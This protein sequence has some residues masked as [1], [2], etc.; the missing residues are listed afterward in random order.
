MINLRS[1]SAL[2]DAASPPRATVTAPWALRGWK[3]GVW[4]IGPQANVGA[5]IYEL[6]DLDHFPR[7]AAVPVIAISLAFRRPPRASWKRQ[8]ISRSSLTWTSPHHRKFSF[9]GISRFENAGLYSAE[10]PSI[11]I[12]QDIQIRVC[13]DYARKPDQV[14]VISMTHLPRFTPLFGAVGGGQGRVLSLRFC[15]LFLL[16]VLSPAGRATVTGPRPTRL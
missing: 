10:P 15:A 2:G 8:T 13:V 11:L 4:P 1:L 5:V 3:S 6:P 7:P 14:A 16:V 9:L 12:F